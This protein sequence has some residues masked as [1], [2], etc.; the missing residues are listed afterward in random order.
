MVARLR[1]LERAEKQRQKRLARMTAEERAA[2]DKWKRDH[3]TGTPAQREAARRGRKQNEDARARFLQP[4]PERPADPKLA[5][6]E[7][8]IAE[9]RAQLAALRDVAPDEQ[10]PADDADP[11]NL[12]LPEIFG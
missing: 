6:I 5:A 10:K 7:A 8:R 11:R 1:D 4:A 3:P 9:L 12:N 2:Y